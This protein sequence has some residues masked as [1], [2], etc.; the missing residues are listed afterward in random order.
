MA[1]IRE[2]GIT[3]K[4]NSIDYLKEYAPS[5]RDGHG[6]YEGWAYTGN[7]G[8]GNTGGSAMGALADQFWSKGGCAFRGF[9]VNGQNDQ[10]GDPQVDALI[11][12]ARVERDTEKNR[13]L[14]FDIQRYLAKPCFM[15]Q[16]PGLATG[17]TVA[18]PCLGNFRVWQGARNNYRWWID[19]TKP[20]FK[21]A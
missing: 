13:A 5:Y 4:V 8:S 10:S 6:Q 15:A 11:E 7:G 14:V 20:P 12:K 1:L 17:L 3:A 18:W 21:S 16:L 19:D 9:S 2:I